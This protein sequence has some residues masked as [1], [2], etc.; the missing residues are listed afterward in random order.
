[1]EKRC[2]QFQN[3]MEAGNNEP[4]AISVRFDRASKRLQI[5]LQD[6]VAMMI[7]VS[8]IQGLENAKAR[9]IETVELLAQGYALHWPSIDVDATVPGLVAVI[10]G[11]KQWMRQIASG[12][13]SKAGR[14]GGSA[15]TG[16]K[17]AAA[18]ANGKL[19]GR[20]RKKVVA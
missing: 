5:E 1:M 2:Q 17:R 8:S 15:S 9:E 12:F 14:K 6:G 13:L 7:P 3:A 4:R 16:A 10:F 18:R 11:T 20:P 19:G